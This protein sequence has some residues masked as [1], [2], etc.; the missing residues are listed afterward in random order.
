VFEFV[1]RFLGAGADAH[2]LIPAQLLALFQPVLSQLAPQSTRFGEPTS[3]P[4]TPSDHDG[5]LPFELG[6]Q[7]GPSS[8]LFWIFIALVA[9]LGLSMARHGRW[10]RLASANRQP[11]PF[12]ALLEAPG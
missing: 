8:L 6:G 4:A 2:V 5:P 12:I 3:A 10:L 1:F 11:V 7:A 9:L